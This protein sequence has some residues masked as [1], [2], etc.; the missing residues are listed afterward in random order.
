MVLILIFLYLIST[1]ICSWA[2][3]NI[4]IKNDNPI[5]PCFL[6][7]PR[8]PAE[9]ICICVLMWYIYKQIYKNIVLYRNIFQMMSLF[10]LV[11][12]QNDPH[13]NY[14]LIQN[15]QYNMYSVMHWIFAAEIMVHRDGVS[16]I[17]TTNSTTMTFLFQYYVAH[18]HMYMNLFFKCYRVRL[19]KSLRLGRCY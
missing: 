5:F 12:P 13:W 7:A 15:D 9:N 16:T 19:R 11:F 18:T 14:E 3:I 10:V 8:D 17:E 1:Q 6:C 2:Q 4:E